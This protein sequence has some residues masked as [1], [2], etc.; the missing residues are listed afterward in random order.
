MK[1]FLERYK[2]DF[3]I[4]LALVFA[5][6][7]L[8]AWM[9]RF[10]QDDA[11]ISFRYAYNLAH[12]HGL[13]WNA[14]ERIEGYTNFL[15]T[16]IIALPIYFGRDPVLSSYLFGL[17]FF[18]ITLIFTYLLAQSLFRSKY[19]AVLTVILLGTN[20]TFSSYATGGLETQLQACIFVACVY[21]L[22][23][24]I[25]AG[26]GSAL[27]LIA[28]SVLLGAGVLTRLDSLLLVGIV[29]PVALFFSLKGNSNPAQKLKKALCL[30]LPF[31]IL[32]GS[33]LVWKVLYYGDILPNTFYV[34]AASGT[35]IER[36][37]VYAYLFF[38]SYWLIPFPLFFFASIR[39]LVER[40]NRELLIP[41]V[42]V[43]LWILYMIKVGG[44][45]ME[46]RFLVPIL[47][48][49]FILMGWLIFVHMQRLELR[50]ALVALVLFGSLHHAYS[51][52]KEIRGIVNIPALHNY[53]KEDG[54][55]ER[56]GR[57]LGEAFNYDP[58]V[59]IATG[60]GGA[61][62]YYSRLKTIDMLGLADKWVA[63]NGVEIGTRPGHQ[64][65][66]PLSY[67]Y[68]RGVNIIIG[69]PQVLKDSTPFEGVG[70]MLYIDPG[71]NRLPPNTK[72]IEIPL[73][74]KHRMF[75]I[76]LTASP[77]VDE[78]IKR[79]GWRTYLLDA[80]QEDGPGRPLTYPVYAPGT[81][82]LINSPEADR[83]LWQGW[84]GREFNSRWTEGTRA[85]FIF[86][87]E[88]L[89][90]GL[91]RLKIAP[92]LAPGKL[93]EQRLIVELNGEVLTVQTLNKQ[94]PEEYSIELPERLLRERNVLSFATPD[95]RA[96]RD[97]GIGDDPRRLGINVQWIEIQTRSD[98]ATAP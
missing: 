43:V 6:L 80:A 1:R 16:L 26:E 4:P 65:A 31:A 24:L 68:E 19:A 74:V 57:V 44:D 27:R 94:E 28:L 20:F 47:P 62:P 13:V 18:T 34:K 29:L 7:V 81:R 83:Y 17:I 21:L 46:F 73:D 91:L 97:L 70:D 39:K 69:H 63:R 8:L 88:Q 72:V 14:G 79:N 90:Q 30:L 71:Q 84:S 37:L 15:Y 35:S 49:F 23:R 51:F 85:T 25:D 50:I 76:Y 93:T 9:N 12:G 40:A 86:G 54:G 98:A 53:V 77:R 96:P 66:A 59:T 32:V 61:I 45:F 60:A 64:R 10:I 82:L 48:L 87:L 52:P 22:V 11:F 95:A 36:G 75:T 89:G 3:R 56:I 5:G 78:V 38:H 58:A 92:F 41:A 42:L 67:L 2:V 33:W 55:W